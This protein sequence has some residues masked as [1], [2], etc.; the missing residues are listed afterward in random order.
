MA[1]STAAACPAA[2]QPP[3]PAGPSGGPATSSPSPTGS[4]AGSTALGGGQEQ[5][6]QLLLRQGCS[7]AA[8]DAALQLPEVSQ[9]RLGFLLELVVQKR[10]SAE[11]AQQVRYNLVLGSTQMVLLEG[12]LCS[13]AGMPS[14]ACGM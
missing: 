14:S 6:R 13:P 12:V 8:A 5:L 2:H 1:S 7:A 4:T 10:V 9:E 3:S 11:D